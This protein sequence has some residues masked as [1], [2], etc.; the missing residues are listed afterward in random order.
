MHSFQRFLR[1]GLGKASGLRKKG[2]FGP[3]RLCGFS[4]GSHWPSM[5]VQLKTYL[6]HPKISWF[7]TGTGM[8]N[9]AMHRRFVIFF[10]QPGDLQLVGELETLQKKQS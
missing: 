4:H 2:A 9:P 5:P 10:K 6:A 1:R 7:E 8:V 3:E